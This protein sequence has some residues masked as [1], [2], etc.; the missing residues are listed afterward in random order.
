MNTSALYDSIFS[1]GGGGGG[2]NGCEKGQYR[3]LLL[4]M[5]V[6]EGGFK[7]LRKENQIGGVFEADCCKEKGSGQGSLT[8]ATIF[9][10]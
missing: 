9:I 8:L 1:N 3:K 6:L 7:S 4:N 5:C 10:V 2:R